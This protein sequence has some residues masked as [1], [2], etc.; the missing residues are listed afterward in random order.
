MEAVATTTVRSSRAVVAARVCHALIA[1]V[2]AASLVVQIALLLSGGADANSGQ[3]GEVVSVG[4]RLWRLF[5][6][7]TIE[8]N[9]FVL[10]TAVVLALRPAADGRIWRVVR[11]DGLLGI[12][13]TGVVYD[14]VLAP[15]V[16]LTGA[17]LAAGIGFHYI[18]PWATILAWLVFGPRRRIT[19]GTI[20][21]AF[22]W[23][24][25]WLVYIFTQGAF[26]DWYPY[27]FLDVTD[28]G[29]G[30]ALVNSLLVVAVAIVFAVLFKLVDNRVPALLRD[31]DR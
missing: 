19:W 15:I 22:V 20:A 8:S 28:L 12:L 23:P 14:I 7:F 9:L 2:V 6:Y 21:G 1:A 16:H 3:A 24:V 13:I 10:A 31:G 27:P 5:S 25:L 29:F 17:A 4:V 18:S 11:L 30:T 26:T